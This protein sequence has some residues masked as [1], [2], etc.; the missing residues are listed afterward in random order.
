MYF[1][2]SIDELKKERQRPA[3]DPWD[4]SKWTEQAVVPTP[5]MTNIQDESFSSILANLNEHK[6]SPPLVTPN[7]LAQLL[8]FH[9]DNHILPKSLPLRTKYHDL[10]QNIKDLA[11]ALDER[12]VGDSLVEAINNDKKIKGYLSPFDTTMSGTDRGEEV[13]DAINSI[14]SKFV[15]SLSSTTQC[16]DD[17]EQPKSAPTSRSALIQP[18]LKVE[19]TSNSLSENDR[20]Q[21][22]SAAFNAFCISKSDLV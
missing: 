22:L 13:L 4:S 11:I 7:T 1:N 15:S 8:N 18:S 10:I 6:L 20:R 3:S 17:S 21:S 12:G 5:N 19:D 2:L 14:L 16:P 9:P